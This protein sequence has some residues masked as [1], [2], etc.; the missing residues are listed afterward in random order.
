MQV[1]LLVA[2]WCSSCQRAQEIWQ[3]ACA[4]HGLTL[5]IVDLDS[6]EGE[7]MAGRHHLKIMPALLIDAH[8]RAIGVQSQVEA[9]ALLAKEIG[10]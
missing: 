6:P 4:R 8:P 10:R 5:Q 1:Q 7:A 3:A 2:S 9:E